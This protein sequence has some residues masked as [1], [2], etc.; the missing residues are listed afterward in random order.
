MDL[1]CWDGRPETICLGVLGDAVYVVA[2]QNDEGSPEVV[3]LMRLIPRQG[4]RL[5]GCIL[6]NR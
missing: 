2:P 4:G 1:G 5:H 6:I 3:E